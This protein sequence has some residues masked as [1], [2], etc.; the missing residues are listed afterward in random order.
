MTNVVRLPIKPRP[1]PVVLPDDAKPIG[2][3]SV[4][5]IEPASK[6]GWMVTECCEA[7]AAILAYG[8]DKQEAV[9]V[10]MIYVAKW[11]A[12]MHLTNGGDAA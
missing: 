11:N 2:G 8:V 6:G 9:R 12:E 10:A 1:R 5:M 3:P 4:V 7:G